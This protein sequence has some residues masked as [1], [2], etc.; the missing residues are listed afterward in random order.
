MLKINPFKPNIPSPASMF[1]GRYD[2]LVLLENGLFQT[3]HHQPANYLITGDRGIGK[4]SLLLFLKHISSG[5]SQSFKHG[6]FDFLTI[7]LSISEKLDVTSLIK[8]FDSHISRELGKVESVRTFLS[9][10]WDFVQRIKVMNSGISPTERDAEVEIQIDNFS[11]SLAATCARIVNPELGEKKKDG[12]V[13]MLDECD[14]AA[15]D[16][17]LGYF[18][19]SVTE[20]LQR[21]DCNNIMFVLAGLPTTQEKLSQS[22]ESAIRIFTQ[23]KIT[24]LKTSDRVFVIKKGIEEG[25]KINAE[26]TSISSAATDSISTLS[27]GYPHFIQQFAYSAFEHNADEEISVED[28]YDAA[29]KPGGAID[30]IGSRYYESSFYDKI[31]SDEYRQVLEIM[32]DK[33]NSWIT[34]AEIR[35]KFLGDEFTLSNALQALTTRK[36]ILKNP[37]KMG[38][39]R[40]QQRGFAIWIRLFGSREQKISR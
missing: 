22:H 29:F 4:S 24:E 3:K 34:K 20:S 28:V 2:E 38:E 39:Y 7:S 6:S 18:F 15:P 23:I 16:L 25:N 33:M 1:A 31:K 9:S 17:R 35:T 32:A 14:N 26:K 37:A 27:E 13:L 8:L 21:L 12:I 30:A 10:T 5:G 19:K 40:L 36:I 11:H